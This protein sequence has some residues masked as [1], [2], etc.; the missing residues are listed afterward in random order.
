MR[1]IYSDHFSIYHY[2]STARSF[3]GPRGQTGWTDP[4]LVVTHDRTERQADVRRNGLTSI[5]WIP[6]LHSP[7]LTLAVNKSDHVHYY[8]GGK[9]FEY[10]VYHPGEMVVERRTL[11]PDL[12]AGHQLQVAVPG[13]SWKCGRMLTDFDGIPQEYAII[14]EGVG[15]GFDFNDFRVVVAEDLMGLPETAQ[16]ALRPYLHENLHKDEDEE[17]REVDFEGFYDENQRRVERAE[18]RSGDTGEP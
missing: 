10:T 14:G 16:E 17:E 6:T 11:G 7:S 5:F 12:G 9:P 13:G 4:K 2:N 18:A 15:P 8:Q 1:I 3:V